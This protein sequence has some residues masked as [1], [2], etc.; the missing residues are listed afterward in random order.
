MYGRVR[1]RRDATSKDNVYKKLGTTGTVL[2]TPVPARAST[3]A[4]GNARQMSITCS[5]AWLIAQITVHGVA[6]Q[7]EAP[8]SSSGKL[9]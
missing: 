8:E 6:G 3:F 2:Y 5:R 1:R 4:A 7:R 9:A